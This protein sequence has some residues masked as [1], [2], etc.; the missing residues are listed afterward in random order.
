[1]PPEST[2][3]G[4]WRD[5]V[6][7]NYGTALSFNGSGNV[8]VP[9]TA[10]INLSSSFTVSAWIKPSSLSGYQTILIKDCNFFL[11]TADTEVSAGISAAGNCSEHRT[12]SANLP[13]NTWS[14]LTAVFDDAA[15]RFNIY[16]N[17]N[18]VASQAENGTNVTN[19][20]SLLIARAATP[21]RTSS[22]GAGSST[23]SGST[24]AR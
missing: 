12:T 14:H 22:A 1:M 11:Q 24:T 16:V 9:S 17:G 21:P 20:E 6:P 10:S 8:A 15:N 2:T 3:D 7:G 23:R 13:L 18:L 19:G 5:L 4:N